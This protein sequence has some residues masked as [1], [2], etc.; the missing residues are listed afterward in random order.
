MAANMFAAGLEQWQLNRFMDEG[1]K[2]CLAQA[3]QKGGCGGCCVVN[4]YLVTGKYDSYR[5]LFSGSSQFFSKPCFMVQADMAVIDSG[6]TLDPYFGRWDYE[7][8]WLYRLVHPDADQM[9]P[10]D[11]QSHIRR[12]VDLFSWDVK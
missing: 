8:S 12:Y 11:N 3:K 6:P 9:R 10:I 5:N 1:L 4:L 7:N 2:N